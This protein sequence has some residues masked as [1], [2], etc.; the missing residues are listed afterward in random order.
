MR[1][2]IFCRVVRVDSGETVRVFSEMTTTYRNEEDKKDIFSHKVLQRSV[3][4]EKDSTEARN[5]QVWFHVMEESKGVCG[6]PHKCRHPTANVF[7]YSH[8]EE[9][10]SRRNVPGTEIGRNRCS[11]SISSG[12]LS[13]WY[14]SMENG[15]STRGDRAT[16]GICSRSFLF[17]AWN[18]VLH[19][20]FGYRET[21]K[22]GIR[23]S[24][25]M[26]DKASK[27][28]KLGTHICL[29]SALTFHDDSFWL[30]I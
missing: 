22:T 24:Q 15:T 7:L 13:S 28:L 30:A 17:A 23:G 10:V 12:S 3:R 6:I 9:T 8:L 2:G 4:H 26:V 1:S 27:K 19:D 20:G 18:H 5:R 16:M 14:G 25:T 29:V 21:G 11:T